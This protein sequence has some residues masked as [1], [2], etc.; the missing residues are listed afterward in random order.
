SNNLVQGGSKGDASGSTASVVFAGTAIGGAIGSGALFTTTTPTLT[1]AGSTPSGKQAPRGTKLIPAPEIAFGRA[2]PNGRGGAI[3]AA[4]G[5]VSVSNSA[6]TGNLAEGGASFTFIQGG[7]V[8]DNAGFQA[9]GG[10]ID[11]EPTVSATLSI[12]NST[13]SGNVALA[14]GPAA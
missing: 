6:I 7:S 1:I 4:A 10:G 11:D 9:E 5:D 2:P 8:V 13:I 12:T 14:T 3:G